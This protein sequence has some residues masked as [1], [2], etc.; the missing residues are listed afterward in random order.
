MDRKTAVIC[1]FNP[2]HK[3]HGSLISHAASVSD[4]VICIMSGN[5]TQR[6]E[7]AVYDK[8]KRAEAAVVMGADL[9]LELPFPYSSAA[10]E[11]FAMGGVSV[12]GAIGA[13]DIIFGS[14]SGDTEYIKE[15]ADL[16]GHLRRVPLQIPHRYGSQHG[17]TLYN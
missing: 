16:R 1:E 17:R 3:G 10:G 5:F 2:F 11:Y 9:V 15:A 12:A 13:T 8:Y 14:E 6:S 7:C 4:I